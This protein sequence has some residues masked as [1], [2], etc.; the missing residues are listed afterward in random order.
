[1]QQNC[2][3]FTFFKG[4]VSQEAAVICVLIQRNKTTL[5]FLFIFFHSVKVL[6]TD[7][8]LTPSSKKKRQSAGDIA[9]DIHEISRYSKGTAASCVPNLVLCKLL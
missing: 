1:M 8:L 3:S 9:V 2:C 7:E 5:Y 6:S 4:G